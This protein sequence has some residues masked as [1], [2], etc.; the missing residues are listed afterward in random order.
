MSN[1]GT[2]IFNISLDTTSTVEAEPTIG[3]IWDG[4]EI[5][6][7]EDFIPDD[8]CVHHWIL[9]TSGKK[10]ITGQCKLC[11]GKREFKNFFES[12]LNH[13]DPL[14][15]NE[16]NISALQ[17]IEEPELEESYIKPLEEMVSLNP[18]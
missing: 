14:I 1:K 9:P 16:L 8:D 13:H 15:D 5:A 10:Y 17:D 12:V 18:A 11:Q 2:L 7:I 4:I 6:P 3:E